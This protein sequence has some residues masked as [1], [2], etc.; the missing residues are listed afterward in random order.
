MCDQRCGRDVDDQKRDYCQP[1]GDFSAAEL[2]FGLDFGSRIDC[3]NVSD[4]MKCV[5]DLR[6]IRTGNQTGT[7]RRHSCAH[8]GDGIG[9]GGDPSDR[10]SQACGHRGAGE[11]ASSVRRRGTR[12]VSRAPRSSSGEHSSLIFHKDR[13]EATFCAPLH[14]ACDIRKRSAIA[15]P[16]MPARPP[17]RLRH[18]FA[19][20]TRRKPPATV[21]NRIGE[22]PVQSLWPA[23]RRRSGALYRGI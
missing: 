7:C 4:H 23:H 1:G 17:V 18:V 20:A 3:L 14:A 6:Q 22:C 11:R 15:G 16:E 9:E 13:G 2:L 21:Y 8:L 5:I 12:S 10:L 19:T